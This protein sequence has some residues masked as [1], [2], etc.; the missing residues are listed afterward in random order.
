[1]SITEG[2]SQDRSQARSMVISRGGIVAAESPLAA[3]A[4]AT[5]LAHGGNAVDAAIATNAVMGLVAP[6]SNGIGGDLFA[7]VYE[8][9]TGKRHG[10]NGSGRAQRKA[11]PEEYRRRGLGAKE[12]VRRLEQ[13]AIELAAAYGV[14]V[15][16]P[17]AITTVLAFNVARERGGWSLPAALAFLLGF[18]FIDLGFLGSNL[19]KVPDGGWLPLLIGL[20]LFT[21]MGTWRKGARLLAERI[22]GTTST[23]ETFIGRIEAERIARIPGTGVFFTGRLEQTPPALQQLV[24]HTGVLYERVIILTVVIEPQP[25]TDPEERIE[26]KDLGAG[27]HRVVL[28]YGFMQRPNIPSELAASEAL[29]LTAELDKV[30]YIIGH[31][32]LLAGRKLRG[33]AR[34]RD[35]LFVLMASN[36]QDAT[37]YYQIPAAQAMKVGLQVGI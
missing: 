37:A 28:H 30:H 34:W 12:L 5:V 23:L 29:N 33:M 11:T 24:R 18:L 31:V 15:N 32:D 35:Q 10:L 13:A 19:L 17:M 20:A 22:A 7:I 6:M 4:G 36:T 25:K 27:F 1:M 2:E 16:S 14:A 26:I 3:Q 8:A 9:K 21:A